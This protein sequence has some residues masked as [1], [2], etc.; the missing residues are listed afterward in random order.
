MKLN[1]EEVAQYLKQNP[2]FFTEY[3]DML[4]DIYIPHPHSGNAIP[5][6]ERQTIALRDQNKIL[7]NKLLEL[8]KFGKENDV[9]GEKMHNLAIKFLTI[10]TL[11]DLLNQLNLILLDNFSISHTEIR[12]WSI[13]F[14]NPEISRF[15]STHK[16]VHTITNNLFDPY[17]GPQLPDE[18]KCWFSAGTDHLH[19][20]SMIPLKTKKA[21]GL[22]VLASEDHQRFH[23]KMETL[24]LKRL[25]EIIST[26]ISRY[27]K[28][29]YD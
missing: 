5:I 6:S 24:Y 12:L 13:N 1:S 26:F 29:D 3:S 25:G 23:P 19:S 8:I 9:I 7:Q 11:I 20:F 2:Q 17:C 16:E 21:T 14:D 18:I 4:S 27:N 10:T 15:I 22:L 28:T